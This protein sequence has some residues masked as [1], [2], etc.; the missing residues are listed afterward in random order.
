MKHLTRTLAALT[1][2]SSLFALQSAP[3][4]VFNVGVSQAAGSQL[5][6]M[7]SDLDEPTLKSPEVTY[8]VVG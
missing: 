2:L 4:E 3:A 6:D 8:A 1:C 5:V 7:T